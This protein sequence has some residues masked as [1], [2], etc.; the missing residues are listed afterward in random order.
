MKKVYVHVEVRLVLDV[1][2]N[3]DMENVIQNLDY[4][5]TPSASNNNVK[6]ANTEITD[7]WL[8]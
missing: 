5:F 1:D 3:T 7:W 6:I 4:N 2:E 8:A